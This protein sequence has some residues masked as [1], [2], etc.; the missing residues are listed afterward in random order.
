MASLIMGDLLADYAK[1]TTRQGPQIEPHSEAR[2]WSGNENYDPDNTRTTWYWT[3]MGL[4]YA[5]A[6]GT[7]IFCTRNGMRAQRLYSSIT[8]FAVPGIIL[9]SRK[10]E[11][12][13]V[14]HVR[15]RT[16][17]ERLEFY[18]ITRRALSRAIATKQAEASS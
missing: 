6:L 1:P 5:A 10:G 2:F 16:L 17:E 8:L 9:A 13:P 4:F 14:G 12:M 15:Q 11:D 3:K 7:Y 18:P